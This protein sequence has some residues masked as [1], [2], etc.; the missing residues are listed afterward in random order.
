MK[1]TELAPTLRI[2]TMSNKYPKLKLAEGAARLD[3]AGAI[4]RMDAAFEVGDEDSQLQAQMEAAEYIQAYT[5][6]LANLVRGD[7]QE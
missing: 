6:A 7:G 2:A 3:L 5:E 4:L 1:I